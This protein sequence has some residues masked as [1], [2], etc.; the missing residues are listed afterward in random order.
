MNSAAPSCFTVSHR[1]GECRARCGEL[2]TLHGTIQTPVFMPVGTQAT[3]KGVTPENLQELG[4]QI[5]L[6]NTY[7]LF[8]RPGHELIRSFGGLHSFMNWDGPIL[9]DSAAAS[10]S[11][12]CG[13]WPRSPRREP[14]STPIWTAQPFSESGGCG[15]G[16]G[17]PGFGYHDV[18]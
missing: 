12:A 8:I 15:A 14:P 4:A 2:T 3:V 1:S 9:T 7:H 5:I 18:P 10:R 17:S 6:G 11:S 16:P 13:T